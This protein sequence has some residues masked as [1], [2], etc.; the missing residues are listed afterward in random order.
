MDTKT[1]NTHLQTRINTALRQLGCPAHLLGFTYVREAVAL[2]VQDPALMQRVT[3]ELYP[4]VAHRFGTTPEKVE[5]AIRHAIAV[6]WERGDV[7][8]MNKLFGYTVSAAKGKPTNSEFIA[9]LAD[10]IRLQEAG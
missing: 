5:R 9:M 6:A 10:D 4:T 3:K 2:T 8:A 1:I 7:E